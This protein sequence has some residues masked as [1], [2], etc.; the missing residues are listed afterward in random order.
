MKGKQTLRAQWL[1]KQLR[2]LR[3]AAHLHMKDAADH[4]QRDA[5]TISR[6]ERGI[7]PPRTPDVLELM[8]LYGVD[9]VVLRAGMENLSRDIWRKGWWDGY[10][11]HVPGKVIDLAWLES[12]AERLR[13]FSALV[14]AGLLQT[15]E[16]AETVIRAADPDVSDNEVQQWIEFRMARQQVLTKDDPVPY[17][18]ILDE[19]TLHRR[20]GGTEVMRAQLQHLL[21]AS[22]RPK[23]TIRVLPFAAGAPASPEGGFMHITLPTPFPDVAQVNTEAGVLYVETPESE[24]FD[25]AYTRLERD[26]LDVEASRACIKSRMEQLE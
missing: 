24:R 5:A 21:D 10:T 20:V 19:A 16:Y 14:F 7:T 4:I 25:E 13:E 11:T 17:T 15:R 2:D 22:H 12:R 3:E 26:A 8:N 23:I 6:I 1:G 9:D 18:A